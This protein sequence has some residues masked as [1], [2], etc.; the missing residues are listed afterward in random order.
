MGSKEVNHKD[1]LLVKTCPMTPSDFI[2]FLKD[3]LEIRFVINNQ[4]KMNFYC[5]GWRS[6]AGKAVAVVLP[7][8]LIEFW[9]VLKACVA[10]DKIIIVQAANTGLTEGSSPH[11]GGYD[12][13]VVIINT[14]KLNK[15][16]VLDTCDQALVFPGSTLHALESALKPLKRVPHSVI[17]SSCL[18]A[19]ATGGVA[20]NSGG[21]LVKRGPAYTEYALYARVNEAG[22]LELVD[23]LGI[24]NLGNTPEQIIANLENGNYTEA[25]V[26]TDGR[27]G[28]DR[29]YSQRVRGICES[30]PARF[31]SDV[32]RL[33]AASGCAG[34]V[35]IFALR[36]DTFPDTEDS[37]TFY[38]GSNDGDD[39]TRLRKEILT[40]FSEL[41][42]MAEYLHRDCFNIAEEYGKDTLLLLK[43]L[44]TEH[45][46]S[47]FMAKRRV[48]NIL[49]RS[50]VLSPFLLDKILQGV[51]R[52]FPGLLPGRMLAFRDL[53]EHHLIIK[54]SGSAVD[55]LKSCLKRLSVS[56]NL[57][58]FQCS[59]AESSLAYLHRF[60]AAGAAL[61]YSL[62]H[63][64]EVEAVLPLDVALP[65]NEA[66][67]VEQL[68]GEIKRRILKPLYY[69]HFLCHVFHQDYLVKKGEDPDEV[70][71]AICEALK[72]RGAKY[73]AEHNVGHLYKAEPQVVDFYKKLDPTNSFNPGIGCTSRLKN[74]GD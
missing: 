40:T 53:Y 10:Y 23:E 45:M 55:E 72:K 58:Y 69:G 5:R 41:P 47:L 28:S 25:D 9:N 6:G 54:V 73:P 42:D 30:D 4:S 13:D 48:E 37:E 29:E 60:A 31:N 22:E 71:H 38:I 26:I 18:G 68:P 8:T 14:L 33:N 20:N 32:R 62:I 66:N 51:S 52:I 63:D 21:T 16:F 61:R 3:D 56:C 27:L 49:R 19:S 12:R 70:K 11:A 65:R 74:Y 15:I 59:A 1:L 64:D 17:G 2:K 67:W 50:R 43:W 35:A 36:L 7:T 44:G 24:R 57:S 46:P 34:K 39:F